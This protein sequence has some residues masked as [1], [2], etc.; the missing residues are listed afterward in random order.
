MAASLASSTSRNIST[1]RRSG[2]RRPEHWRSV[3]S[4]LP[5]KRGEVDK[6]SR[7]SVVAVGLASQF[8]FSVLLGTRR[9]VGPQR[10]QILAHRAR[11]CALDL[12][13]ACHQGGAEQ[14]QA[15][16]AAVLAP[17]LPLHR[18]ALADP[19]DLID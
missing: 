4:T 1:S 8:F 17:G 13:V 12:A 9:D 3:E 18:G 6:T 14:C 7:H 2:S 5:R 19:I 10:L 15:G 11:R 16:A